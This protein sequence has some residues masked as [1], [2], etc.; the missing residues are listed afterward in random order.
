MR[1][2]IVILGL[3]ACVWAAWNSGR[4]GLSEVFFTY[5]ATSNQLDAADQAVRL[6]PSN[7][8]AH[9]VRAGLLAKADQWSEATK[10]YERASSFRPDDYVLWL[11]LGRARD[12]ESDID[13][14]LAAFA[15]STRHAQFY[16][17][18]HW[19][20]G[21]LLFRIGRRDEA[22]VELRIAAASDPK[23]LPQA[24]ALAWAAF[25]GNASAVEEAIQPRT[26]SSRLALARFLA[27]HGRA[28]EALGLFR[29]TSG[30][31]AE[32]RHSL[33]AALLA[34]KHFREAF[35]VWSAIDGRLLQSG[36]I[37]DG[38]FESAIDLN[39]QGFGWRIGRDLRAS[40]VS[41]D[42]DKPYNGV[43]SLR[44][45]WSGESDPSTAVISQLVLVEP[46]T[47]YRLSFA[48]RT[49]ELLTV[50]LPFV[51][52]VDGGDEKTAALMKSKTLP[53]GTSGWQ[54]YVTEFT[55][56]ET[57]R[58]VRIGIRRETCATPQCAVFGHVWFDK[59]SLE[60][61]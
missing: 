41:L 8:D 28:V 21:N 1:L 20:L 11:E 34:G 45:D 25:G 9:Y 50:G 29:T 61:L 31:S 37:T 51:M 3:T 49:Q 43:Y 26:P 32:D 30:A 7:A 19:L 15:E 38:S 52:V 35:E 57:T 14:A 27:A 33:L 59:F 18:P 44:I 53:Q 56:P 46:K 39:E 54:D 17:K 22:L 55:T 47:R 24:V 4:E 60:R 23:L 10:E 12:R 2:V 16:A 6:S 42:T 48:A 36:A 5:A 40:R 13:G 58:A